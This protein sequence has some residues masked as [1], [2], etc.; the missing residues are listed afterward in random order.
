MLHR[1]LSSCGEQ[2]LLCSCGVQAGFCLRWLF[3]LR[4]MGSRA[5]RFQQL[6]LSGSRAQ[7]Q[8]LWHMAL[9]ALQHVGYSQTRDGTP[10]LLH[11]QVDSLLFTLSHQGSPG[12]IFFFFQERFL[13]VS[14]CSFMFETSTCG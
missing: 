9:I 8:W 12:W 2:G 11:W 1:L 6:R 4:R 13:G 10:C 3:L 7:A 5:C 14:L